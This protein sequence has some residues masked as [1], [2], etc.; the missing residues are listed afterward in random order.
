[1][2]D[3]TKINV[4]EL[5]ASTLLD[6]SIKLK[7][8]KFQRAYSWGEEKGKKAITFFEEFLI[9]AEKNTFCGSLFLFG[10]NSWDSPLCSEFYVA[11]GQHRLVSIA[12][13]GFLIEEF[14]M[15][16]TDNLRISVRDRELLKKLANLELEVITDNQSSPLEVTKDLK[17]LRSAEKKLQDMLEST[18]N[19]SEKKKIKQEIEIERKKNIIRELYQNIKK[20]LNTKSEVEKSAIII[21]F[22]ARLAKYSF[23]ATILSNPQHQKDNSAL[24]SEAYELFTNINNHA[25]PLTPAELFICEVNFR[26]SVNTQASLPARSYLYPELGV[27]DTEKFLDF[28]FKFN[29]LHNRKKVISWISK[30]TNEPPGTGALTLKDKEEEGFKELLNIQRGFLEG[31]NLNPIEKAIAKIVLMNNSSSA[32]LVYIAHCL[33]NK[34]NCKSILRL[35]VLLWIM[36]SYISN[37]SNARPNIGRDLKNHKTVKEG[38]E[39]IQ[40]HFCGKDKSE[41]NFK[42]ILQ[43]HLSNFNFGTNTHTKLA[44]LLLI[45]ANAHRQGTE[46][47]AGLLLDKNYSYEHVSPQSTTDEKIVHLLGNGALITQEQNSS[48]QDKSPEE[49]LIIVSQAAWF[50][51]NYQDLKENATNWDEAYIRRRSRILS[52]SICGWLLDGLLSK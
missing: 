19:T 27:S 14:L 51:P 11:D 1:M 20:N 5:K 17:N 49:K 39:Y 32:L 18:R 42:S 43:N 35:S 52:E 24:I 12:I 44:K 2:T 25:E 34:D 40:S 37:E 45:V 21:K 15:A 47:H 31:N 13:Y 8:P 29:E 22:I 38:L 7:M 46:N 28:I 10:T 36:I 30:Y 3:S 41:E 26:N 9:D 16:S 4:L 33:N 23:G 50:P 6:K 48:L